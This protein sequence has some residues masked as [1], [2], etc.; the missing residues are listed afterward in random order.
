MLDA[1]LPLPLPL[2]LPALDAPLS[3]HRIPLASPNS[4]IRA[5][6]KCR[7]NVHPLMAAA[8]ADLSPERPASITRHGMV[9]LMQQCVVEAAPH[10][11]FPLVLGDAFAFDHLPAIETFLATSPTLRQ[12]LPALQWAGQMMPTMKMHWEEGIAVSAIVIDIDLPTHSEHVKGWFAE[13]LLAGIH[14]F[15]RLA[16]GTGAAGMHVELAHDPGP[17]RRDCEAH[18]KLPVRGLAGRNALVFPT[19]VLDRHLPG[20]VPGLHVRA[21]Q[22]IEQQMPAPPQ[23]L[24]ARL[25]T[26]FRQQ[27]HLLGQGIERL[28]DRMGL[29]PR[30]LQRRLQ[31]EGHLF[32]DIQ[33]RCRFDMA[34]QALKQSECSIEAL[35]EQLGFSD[36]HSFT[37]A[38]RRWTGLAP[39]EFRQQHLA[40][41]PSQ[42]RGQHAGAH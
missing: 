20:A 28:A 12:A 21:Q 8:Q 14:K 41:L 30:T 33:A 35:S 27:P 31:N 3:G 5:A 26:L 7:F 32:A 18:F 15:M 40:Q 23:G 13:G 42:P 10:H 1:A 22:M 36:R 16:L 29:H 25:E 6:L 38:F 11:H 9:Q 39:T 2:A 37:R 24:S 17:Q 4:W 34:V 19:A